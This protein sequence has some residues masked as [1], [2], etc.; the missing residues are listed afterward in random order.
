MQ[1]TKALPIDLEEID[2]VLVTKQFTGI[3]LKLIMTF[4]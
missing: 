1:R 3:R 4:L 2:Q